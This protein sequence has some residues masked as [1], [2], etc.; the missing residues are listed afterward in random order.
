[1]NIVIIPDVH[2][3]RFWRDVVAGHE[4]DEIVFL[5]DYIDPYAFEKISTDD[6]WKEF[7][8]IIEFKKEHPENVTLLL[9]NHDLGYI[10]KDLCRVRMDHYHYSR[11][12]GVF[13]ENLQLFDIVK[14]I[15][16]GGKKVLFS[17]A[18]FRQPWVDAHPELWDGGT[19]S[20]AALNSFLHD[21]QKLDVLL[22]ALSDR[23]WYR[24]GKGDVGSPVWADIDEFGIEKDPVEGY[25]QIIGHSL[26]YGPVTVKGL[27]TSVDC[28][29]GFLLA[30]GH[31]TLA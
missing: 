26:D 11:N 16:S 12:H 6:A 21:E 15:E 3:R 7:M 17:H 4:Q 20:P 19:F 18:G 2:G 28:R 29:R 13:M 10:D 25:T 31:L 14:E 27:V 30:D 22:R 1:M 8:D 5:G 23:S 24:G 9:G